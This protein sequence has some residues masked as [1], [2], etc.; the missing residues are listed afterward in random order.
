M[1]RKDFFSD[2][3]KIYATFR[4]TYPQDLYD[5]VFSHVLE[6]NTA[7]DCGTGNG[8]VAQVLA[9]HFTIVY[10]TDIS[11]Q[12]ID[13]AKKLDN[14]RYSVSAAEHTQFNPKMFDLITVGQALHW[15][16]LDEFYSEVS[17]T[18]KP[19]G[20][21]AIWG[22]AMLNVS[23][24]IDPLFLKFYHD[25]VGRYWDSAR[26]MVEEEYKSIP[27]PF[28]EIATPKFAIKVT[29]SKEQFA[30]YVRSWSATQKFMKAEGYDPVPAFIESLDQLWADSE[31]K[32][33]TF[34]LFLKL[35]RIQ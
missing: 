6:K 12:Q 31:V 23:S 10:A 18:I 17:R 2:H 24:Q 33:V 14:V 13:Q 20:A 22:Y 32:L 11:Q 1:E 30:G 3:S 35:A 8:Q 34:P 25:K 29:W 9:R 15:F 21:L 7:W 16:N 19:G 5:F 26:R 28:Q 4:P 27:F